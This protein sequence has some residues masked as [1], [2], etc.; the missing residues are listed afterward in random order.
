MISGGKLLYR[1]E[2]LAAMQ[3]ITNFKDRIQ[4][5]GAPFRPSS[6]CGLDVRGSLWT[7]EPTVS[8]CLALLPLFIAVRITRATNRIREVVFH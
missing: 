4:M 1:I 6:L 8:Y 5:F 7:S 3:Y 2:E